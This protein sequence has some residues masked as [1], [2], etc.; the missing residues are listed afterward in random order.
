MIIVPTHIHSDKIIIEVIFTPTEK[1][2][3]LFSTTRET[4]RTTKQTIK[5]MDTTLTITKTLTPTD[6][7]STVLG[8]LVDEVREKYCGD[9]TP[10]KIESVDSKTKEV[11]YETK[12]LTS[13]P[14]FKLGEV[15]PIETSIDDV[16]TPI[17]PIKPTDPIIRK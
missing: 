3:P 10:P 5:T 9:V 13:N 8:Q 2:G 16:I 1:S 4:L 17:N 6:N 14:Q 7:P 11:V 12:D 15:T